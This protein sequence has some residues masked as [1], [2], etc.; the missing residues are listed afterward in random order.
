MKTLV[1][2][3]SSAH[4][5]SAA[6]HFR[7]I[8]KFPHLFLTTLPGKIQNGTARRVS[9][10]AIFS[11]SLICSSPSKLHM[12]GCLFH[13][14]K[15]GTEVG[16][17]CSRR[18]RNHVEVFW[19]PGRRCAVYLQLRGNTKI[20]FQIMTCSGEKTA[21]ACLKG[22]YASASLLRPWKATREK[23]ARG[24]KGNQKRLILC[25]VI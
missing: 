16:C 21:E 6:S 7:S 22:L 20:T 23:L 3:K 17:C 10:E 24:R 14:T 1:K 2:R 18:R 9:A 8:H 12:I 25:V 11:P 13:L 19:Y 5:S 4:P 15:I